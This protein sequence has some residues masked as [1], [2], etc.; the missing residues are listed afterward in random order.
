MTYKIKQYRNE[1]EKKEAFRL[2]YLLIDAK[3]EQC[4]FENALFDRI[5]SNESQ[6]T[7]FITLSTFFDQE[8]QKSK[9]CFFFQ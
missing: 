2:I 5:R 1:N 7:H 3:F 6:H 8:K 4:S 9:V